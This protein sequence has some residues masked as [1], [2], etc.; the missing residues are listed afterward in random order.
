MNVFELINPQNIVAY[1]DATNENQQNYLGDRLFPS[2]K[3]IGLELSKLTGRAS[4]PVTLKASA[5]DTQ[6]TYRDRQSIEI[7]KT[8]LPLYRERYRIDETTRQQLLATSSQPVL[9]NLVEHIFDDANDLRR[10]A[11]VAREKAAMQLL[12]TGHVKI[13]GNGVKLDYDYGVSK[14]QKVSAATGWGD[15]VNSKPLQDLNDWVDYAQTKWGVSLGYVIM[16]PRTFTLLK[17]SES[18]AFALYPTATN[19]G[20]MFVTSQ[21]V[22]DIVAATT[23]LTVLVYKETYKDD[24]HSAAKPFFPDGVVTL[25]PS[26]GVVGNTYFGTTP[27][28][29]DLLNGVRQA[30]TTTIVD[31]GVALYSR[32]I[33]HPVSTEIICSQVCLPAFSSDVESGAGTILIGKVD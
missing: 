30:G 14:A 20:K 17:S 18:I 31:T 5:F 1:W 3:V 15:T 11:K 22:K 23:G 25:I 4:V 13:E 9:R 7:Q 12:T 21:Q 29:A 2:R 26:S 24:L 19:A 27:E 8:N 16:S 33:D 10:G 28:E 6:A 32:L